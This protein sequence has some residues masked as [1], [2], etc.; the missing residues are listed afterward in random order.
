MNG[1]V[2]DLTITGKHLLA[3]LANDLYSNHGDCLWELVRNSVVA[4]MLPDKWDPKRAHVEVNLHKNHS[5][6]PNTLALEVFD[7]GCGIPLPRLKTIG[8]SIGEGRNFHGAAQKRIGRFAGLALN[9]RCY[10]DE[11]IE[12]G[13]Y[14]MTRTTSE[15]PVTLVSM[16]PALLEARKPVIS[17]IDPDSIELGPR[18]GTK[19]TF[20]SIVVPYSVFKSNGEIRDALCWKIPRKE[21]LMFKLAVDGKEL[22]PPPLAS[23]IVDGQDVHLG[24]EAY[25]DKFDG[26]EATGEGIWLT[27]AAT[28]LRVA[29]APHISPSYLPYPLWRTD[30]IGD[31]FAPGLLENQ[32]A[33]RS[34]LNSKFFKSTQWKKTVGFLCAKIV[35]AVKALLGDTDVFHKN[36]AVERTALDFVNLCNK[37]FGSPT[38]SNGPEFFDDVFTVRKPKESGSGSGGGKGSN[39]TGG[40]GGKTKKPSGGDVIKPRVL[41]F[42]VDG[43]TYLLAKL[44]ADQ[45]VFASM[46]PLRTKVINLN[47]RYVALPRQKDARLEHVVCMV[48]GAIS[49]YKHPSDSFEATRWIAEQRQKLGGCQSVSDT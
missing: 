28:G 37:A 18:R 33:S 6:A 47:S 1:Q 21:A 9:S 48:L 45:R 13:F 19:G 14:I 5:L 7:K 3:N 46:D 49:H 12:T 10:E 23:R 35:P 8:P 44:P 32:D 25:I 36:N 16:I 30:L 2:L 42:N 41:P 39:G 40:G 43:E 26:D 17:T 24:V 38:E 20:T 29:F 4:C 31:I 34:S 11:D 22:G 27:D 15:G